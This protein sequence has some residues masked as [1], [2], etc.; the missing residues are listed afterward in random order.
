[1]PAIDTAMHD[2]MSDPYIFSEFINIFVF[3]GKP[4]LTAKNLDDKDSN[5]S[6][7]IDFKENKTAAGISG[8]AAAV[9]RY[10]DVIKKAVIGAPSVRKVPQAALYLKLNIVLKIR[11]SHRLCRFCL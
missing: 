4:V 9:E 10:R 5:L 11:C 3:N 6:Q 1:M 7:M 2:F 8:S